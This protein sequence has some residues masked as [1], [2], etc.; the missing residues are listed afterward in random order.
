MTRAACYFLA[1]TEA[2]KQTNKKQKKKR[3]RKKKGKRMC[4]EKL[5]MKTWS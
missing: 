5:L 2:N 1:Y 4:N 3:E